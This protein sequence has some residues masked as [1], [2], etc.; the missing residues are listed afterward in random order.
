M[1]NTAGEPVT[2]D[3]EKQAR[4]EEN[5]PSLHIPVLYREALEALQLRDG[6]RY[7]DATLGGAGHAK[8]IL[9]ETAPSGQLLGLDADPAAIERGEQF[10]QAYKERVTLVCANFIELQSV[11]HQR[12]FYPVNGIL[13]D[14]G[15]SSFQLADAERGFSLRTDGP[16]DMRFDPQQST[17]AADLV[18]TLPERELA[19]ILWEYGEERLSRRIAR[20][21]VAQRPL[22]TTGELAELIVQVMPRQKRLH[23]ATRTFQALRI[24]VNDE[25][26]ALRDALAQAVDLLAPLGRVVVISFHSLEDRIVKHFFRREARDCICPSESFFCTCDHR[27]TLS[28]IN[29]K[30]I[31][32]QPKE[33]EENPRSRSAKMRVAYKLPLDS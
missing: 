19:Q 12:N 2:R 32:P 3:K 23:P 21:V 8:G 9:E 27:A 1:R 25:L 11:A 5:I 6:G 29:K 16:L 14:L 31:T 26:Q 20:A 13:F 17:T 28:I 33:R 7:V 22:R 18:N 10:L 30:P 15:L 4:H 24:A